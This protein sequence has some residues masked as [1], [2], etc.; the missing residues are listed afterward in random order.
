MFRTDKDYEYDEM[1]ADTTL[2]YIIAPNDVISFRLFT[3][4]GFKLIDVTSTNNGQQFQQLSQGLPYTV[5]YDGM[6][7]LPILNRVNLQGKTIREA[8]YFLEDKYSET[9]ID[10]F[11]LLSVSN[12]RVTIFPGDGG[13]GRVITLENN[14]IKL[15]EALAL[16]GGLSETGRAKR[17]KLIRG[18]LSNPQIYEIDL[19]RIENV[20]QANIILQANDIIYVEPVGVT[21]RQVLSEIAPILGLVTSLLTLYVVLDRL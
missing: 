18:D 14:N 1:Q 5:E 9:F 2:E 6:V 19:S 20:S 16:A 17:I 12:R 3:N 21:T 10:P 11:V 15:L 4:N 7:N 13:S 8:E